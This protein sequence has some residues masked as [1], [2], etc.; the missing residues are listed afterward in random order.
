VLANDALRTAG[1]AAPASVENADITGTSPR[2]GPAPGSAGWFSAAL[3]AHLGLEISDL[4][5]SF[6][7]YAYDCVSLIAIAAQVAESNE[8]VK[9]VPRLVEISQGGASCVNF[10]TCRPLLDQ[11][12]N[13]D[14][15]GASGPLEL[16]ADGDVSTGWFDRFGF[17]ENGLD[18]TDGD[19]LITSS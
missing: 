13:I 7:A 2:A 17:T 5:P 8:A 15:N 11:G 4:P 14:L 9:I 3:A 10:V 6:A 12:R 16:D 19:L 18:V 1:T